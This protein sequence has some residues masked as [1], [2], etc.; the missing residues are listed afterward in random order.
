[1]SKVR[2]LRRSKSWT[3][4]HLARAA[5]LNVRTIQRFETS[6]VAGPETLLAIAGALDVPVRELTAETAEPSVRR[7]LP[8]GDRQAGIVA[9][10]AGVPGL[11]FLLA[12]LIIYGGPADARIAGG[13]L[14]AVA[15]T[16]PL[17]VLG[18]LLA[19]ALLGLAAQVGLAMPDHPRRHLRIDVRPVLGAGLAGAAGGVAL[20]GLL[21]ATVVDQA[22]ESLLAPPRVALEGREPG[23]SDS[24]NQE[25]GELSLLRLAEAGSASLKIGRLTPAPGKALP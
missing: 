20:A 7:L 13:V 3:Q 6:G 10:A 16:P 1:M 25:E 17:I 4:E 18:S 24:R 19:C 11:A 2:T 22:R 12:N 8:L 15:A 9:A 21:Y 5:G 23:A 14:A